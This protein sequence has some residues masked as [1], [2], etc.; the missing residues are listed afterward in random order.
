MQVFVPCSEVSFTDSRE[1]ELIL[2]G[3]TKKFF[4]KAEF[5]KFSRKFVYRLPDDFPLCMVKVIF[6]PSAVV[7]TDCKS[8]RKLEVVK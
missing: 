2:N 4:V 1:I 3:E 8:N 7:E 6:G 5:N